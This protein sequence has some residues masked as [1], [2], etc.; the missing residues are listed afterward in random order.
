MAAVISRILRIWDFIRWNYNM[1]N[2]W[3]E[4]WQS[5]ESDIRKH[6]N[7]IKDLASQDS[8]WDYKSI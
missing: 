4:E 8:H 7:A 3:F 1:T 5:R 2:S 6:H